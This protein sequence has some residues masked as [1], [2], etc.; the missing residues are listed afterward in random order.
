MDSKSKQGSFYVGEVMNRAIFIKILSGT[1][2]ENLSI[3]FT[4]K[5]IL[6]F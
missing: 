3:L 2:S 6:D 1:V 5:I 4:S